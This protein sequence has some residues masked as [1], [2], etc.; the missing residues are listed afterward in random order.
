M[1]MRLVLP[2]ADG[3]RIIAVERVTVGGVRLG[4]RRLRAVRGDRDGA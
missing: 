2:E 4:A 1:A 3:R